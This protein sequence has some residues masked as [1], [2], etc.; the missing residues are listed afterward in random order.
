[1]AALAGNATFDRE[2][3]RMVDKICCCIRAGDEEDLALPSP[4]EALALRLSAAVS[5]VYC[6]PRVST[7]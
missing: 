1:M 3:A 7:A 2:R 5:P 4:A 6:S